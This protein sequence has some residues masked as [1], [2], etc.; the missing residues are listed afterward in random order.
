MQLA[1][2]FQWFR[3]GERLAWKSLRAGALRHVGLRSA[4]GAFTRPLT[5]P[6]RYPEYE[7]FFRLLTYALD[8]ADENTWLLDVG[9]PKLF[10]LLLASRTRATIV[11]TDVWPPAIAEADALR[12]GLVPS[13]AARVHLGVLDVREPISAELRP[14]NA[15]FAGAFAMSVIEHVE[16]DP[17][18]DLLALV[19]MAEV[20]RPGG[21]IVVSVPVARDSRSEY[22]AS[23]IYG[24]K[25]EGERGAFFQR[26]YDAD[27]L[28][29][30]CEATPGLTLEACVHIE[31]PDNGLFDLERNLKPR[32]PAAVGL[33]GAIY[34]LLANRFVITASSPRIPERIRTQ[35]DTIL[36]LRRE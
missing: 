19:R 22:L 8:L 26:V 21:C 10:S 18:G 23:E 25:P 1:D 11:A 15:S 12:V 7:Q 30:L 20:V 34:P 9:S 29:G 31:W 2:A 28:R 33:M 13:A 35:G 5:S 17:G 3:A 16:P 36:V 6:S 14:P 32:F 4:I 27:A 24:R